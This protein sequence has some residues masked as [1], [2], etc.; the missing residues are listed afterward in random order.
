MCESACEMRNATSESALRVV[1]IHFARCSNPLCA[2][3]ESALRGVQ[4]GFAKCKVLP[5]NPLW[6][7]RDVRISFAK[8]AVRESALRNAKWKSDLLGHHM[9]AISNRGVATL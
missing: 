1:R 5:A 4:I 2:M 7:V 9:E 6:E 3:F 8:S